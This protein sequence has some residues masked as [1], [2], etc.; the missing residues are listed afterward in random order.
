MSETFDGLNALMDTSQAPLPKPQDGKTTS[1]SKLSGEGFTVEMP[2]GSEYGVMPAGSNNGF[3][4]GQNGMP[5]PM[6]VST[7]PDPAN[8]APRDNT[9]RT[10]DIFSALPTL[11]LPDI[12]P[13][14]D[15]A[16]SEARLAGNA[17]QAGQILSADDAVDAS[18]GYVRGIGEN[19][20][21][22]QVND[23]LNQVGHARI[24]FGSNK[25]GDADV[26]VPLID[27]PNSLFFSQIGLRANEERTTTNLGLGYRQYEDGWMWGVNSFYDYDITGSNSRVGVGGELWA[28]YLKFAAN[29]YFRVTDWH[30]STLHEM[31]DYDER[32]ANGFDIRAEGYLPDY[33]QVGAFAKYEQYFGDGVSLASTTS[34]GELKSNPS[35]S[36][37]GLSYTPF[38]LI[39]FKGQTSRGDSNDSQVG[40]ELSYRFGVPLSQ[41]LDTDNVDLM[42]NLAGNRYDFVDR[43]YNIVMQ[44]RKQELLRIALPPALHGEA[45]QTHPVTV[46][47]LKAKYGLKSLRWSAPE[48]LA[49]GGEIRQ[50]GLTTADITLPEYVFMDRNGGPQGYRVTVVGE[51]N[52]GNPS[53][54]AEMWVNVIPSVETVTQLTVTPNQS[55]VANNRDQFTAVA[56]LQNDKGEVL[57]DKAVTFSVSGLKNPEGVTIY[58]ADGNSGQ[59]LTVISGPDGMATVKIISK[60]AGKGL[61]KAKMRNGNSRT[62]SIVYIA[63]LSTAKIK[64]LELTNNKAVADGQAKNI[65]VATVTDQFDNQVENFPL[66]ARADNGAT[67]TDPNQQT[68]DNGQVT[69]RFSSETA[70]D[71]KL[72]VEGTGTSKSVTSQFVADISTA[73]IQSA[74][75]TQDGAKADGKAKNEVLVTVTDS[76]NNPLAGAPVTIKVPGTARYQ[77]QPVSGLTDSRGQLRVSISNTKAGSDNYTFSINGDDAV[78]ALKFVA[79]ETTATITDASLVIV[80]NNQKADGAAANSVRATIVDAYNNPVPGIAV[81]FVT[82]HGALPSQ[83]QINTDADG[84]ALFELTNTR[85]G[86]TKVTAQVNTK[87]ASKTVMF[88]ADSSTAEILASNL[89]ITADNSAADGT[90]V[91]SVKAIVTDA[92]GNVVPYVAVLFT[93]DNGASPASQSLLTNEQGEVTF[94]LTSTRAVQVAVKAKINTSEPSVTVT[95]KADSANPDAQKSS[96][97]ADPMTIVADGQT[98]STL[99]FILKD[100]Q[101]N[102]IPGQTVVFGTALAGTTVSG[103]TE[104]PDGTYTA[105]L[106]GVKAGDAKVSITLNG[107]AFAVTPVTVKLTADNGNLSGDKSQ[108]TAVPDTIVA[109]GKTSSTLTLSLK[110]ANDNAV[111]GQEVVFSTTL[112][113]TVFSA[114]RDNADGTYTATLKGTKS[115]TAKIKVTVNNAVLA[116]AEVSVKLTADSGNL[117]K[118]KSSLA[119]V[120]DTIVAD[121]NTTSAITLTLR[122]VNNNPVAGQTALFS[123]TLKD[124]TFG[125]VTDNQDGTYTATLKGTKSGNAQ[126]SVTLNGKAFAVAPVTVKLTA[127]SS[128]LD[129]DKSSL[130]AAPLSIVANDTAT[131]SLTLTL[132]DGNDNPVPGQTVL[133]S[134]T[135]GGTT[136]SGVTD[137]RDGTYTATL[138]G[139]TAGDAAL[140]VT[141]NGAVLTVAP[142]TVKLT[143]DSGNLDKDQSVLEASPL[144]IV[145]NDTTTS[146]LKLTLKDANGNLVSGQTVLFST[147]L[148]GTTFSGVT[149]NQDGTYTAT[150]KGKTAGDAALKVTVNGTELPV[151]QVIVTLT[152]DSTNLDKN[153]SSLTAAPLSIVADDASVSDLKLT[154]KDANGNLVPGQQVLFSTTLGGTTFSGVTDNHDGT[155][156][157]TLKGTKAGD[158]LLTVT[159]NGAVLEVAPVTVKLTADS[160]NLDKDQSVLE[161]S[162]LS[163]VANDTTT[164]ALK[165][166]LKDGN[167]NLVSGQTVLFSTTLANTTFGTVTDNQDGTYTAT[168]KGKTAGDAVIKVTVGGNPLDVAPVTV[169]LTPDSTN[170][171]KNKSSL[172]AVPLSIVADDTSVSDLKLILK[173]ANGN[174]V[175]GQQV[176]FSTTLGG[177]TFSGVTDNHD[178]TYTATL[179]GTKAGDALLTVTVNGAVLE[180]APVTVTLTADNGNLDKNQSVLEAAPLN[181]V[182]NGTAESTL[183]L[184]LKDVNGNLVSGQVVQFTTTLADTT[185][186][187]V[188]DNRDGTY[189]ATLKGTKSGDAP[190][191]VIVNGTGL[192]VAPV[193]VTLTPDSANPDKDKSVLTA[194][195]LTIVADDTATS[196]LKLTLKDT[197]GNLIPGQTVLFS[198]DLADTTFSTVKDNHDGT[199]TAT[200]KGTKSGTAALKVT[201]NGAVLEV[202]PVSVK[203]IGDKDHLDEDKSSLTAAPLSIVANNTATSSLTLTLKDVNDNPV[204]G[205]TV[206]FSTDLADTT[207][208]AVKDNQDG[209]YTATLKGTK[210]GNALLKVT[211]NGAVLDVAPV[212]VKLTA[213]SGN[214]DKN[215]S[216]LTAAP[217]SIVANNTTTSE[218]KLT[219]KDANGNLVSGQT[220]LFST[221]LANTTFGTVTDNQDGTYTATLK[222]KTA[223]DAVIKVTVG[224]NALEV[225]P[226]TVTLTADSSNLDNDK[227]VLEAT[228]LSIVADDATESTLKLT[229]KDVNGNLVSGQTVLFSTTLGGTTISAVKDNQDGTYTALLKGKTA[230]AAEIK[231]T[232]GGNALEVAPVTVT[233]TPD[234]SNLDEGK[235]SLTA[236]PL[237]IVANNITESALTLT[238]KDVNGNLVPGQTVLF[239]TGLADT[240][241]SGVTDNQDGTYTATLKG[242]KAGNA[243]LKVTINGAVLEVAPVTVKLIGDQD[244]LDKGKSAL[245]ADPLTIVANNTTTSL[246]KLTLKDVNDN[247]VTGQ[248]VL[249]ST[250]L[251]NT[252]F[253]TVTDNQDGTYTANLQG[254]TAG[255]AVIKVTVGGTELEVAPVTVTL[256]ADS[257]NLDKEKSLLTAVPL[258]IVADDAT[259]SVLTLTLK[260]GNDNLVAGQT[261]LFSTGLADTTFSA[262]KDNQDGTYTATLKGTKA[263][264]A[265][266]KVTVNGAVLEVAPVTV[267]LTADSSNLDKNKSV[268]TADPLTIVANN[269]TMSALKLTLKDANGNLVSGQTVLFSTDLADT[270]F[271]TVVANPDGTYTTTLKGTKAGDALLKVTVNGTVLEV[272]PVTVKLTADSSNLDKNKSSLTAAPLTIVANNTATSEVTLTLKDAYDN[273]VAGQTVLFST[274][275]ANTTFGTVTDNH[276]G[277][278]T[279]TLKGT[280]AGD[281]EIKVTVGGN[282]LEV[283]SVTVKLTADSSNLD[284][285]K[286]VLTATPLTIVA[287][288]TATSA[289]KLTLKDANDNPVAGQTVLFSTTLGG[290]TFSGV[291]DN[292]DGTY[293]ATLKGKTA[294]DAPLTVT[295]NGT[296]M[297]VAVVTVTLTGD[298]ATATI[299]NVKLNGALT[300]KIA[301]GTD[302]FEFIAEVRD[303]NGNAVS[304]V[305]VNWTSTAGTSAKL[306]E[307]SQQTDAAGNATVKLTSTKTPVYDIVI[308]AAQGS[309]TVKADKEVSF[310]ELFSTSVL[311]IDAI[312]AGDKPVNG[313]HVKIFSVDGTELLFETT[314][315][316]TGKFKV[317]LV[318]GK[319]AVKITANNYDDYDDFMVVKSG[320]DTNFKF[321]LSPALG[322]EFGR[323]ILQ[324]SEAPNDLDAHLL[325]PPVGGGSRIHVYYPSGSKDPAGA[326]AS[327]DKDQ[328]SPPGVETITIRKGHKGT[329]TYFVKRYSAGADAKLSTAK[330]L[331]FLNKDLVLKSGTSRMMSFDA[332]DVV[333]PAKAQWIVFDIIVD[334][335][336]E[337]QVVPKGTVT[338]VEPT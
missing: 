46:S 215:K 167:G 301:N 296:E 28:N 194:A 86:N 219:L 209:T 18:L 117:D 181:I 212:T 35:V 130:T 2:S 60:S 213:D 70:G 55:L 96:L 21:N 330:V 278:Y 115:G 110:D 158:A 329:Y 76:R 40:M 314:T 94:S 75:V 267:K 74:V 128:N 132:K 134:T 244:N 154:L 180:V 289:L 207:F 277:T 162:P 188:T 133:F 121:G 263:G 226:V 324:W 68:D 89:T 193:T 7:L 83:M 231:V 245:T 14:D 125:T 142:V 56:L 127:D 271:D 266:L 88:T 206:L 200:L 179:K 78:R 168:L 312:A 254:K 204:I 79:D 92:Q 321:A 287:N 306:S 250:G 225:A 299:T 22:Q 45:A 241:F 270:T 124:T 220:V 185:F 67:V 157:A 8:P 73:K 149:D 261:V 230:G 294:G 210:A 259:E 116:V 293:T 144:S 126:I 275:L 47:V 71:S 260:D 122:D 203:L 25:T 273:P 308:S 175:P 155:Y 182:A 159:V 145:A 111:S 39:T 283:A 19:L 223:G 141:V 118:G 137:N 90:S 258:T 135:L 288:N 140:K 199:Y 236:V 292:Q 305:T 216:S 161:A 255:A 332:P 12:S 109:D 304:G 291:T 129:K 202:A 262:V 196:S 234:S 93:A 15:A 104:N 91:N 336:N 280:K 286:S 48:L 222:G 143:A 59:T 235:S 105:T 191:T 295:V 102:L 30:Q 333:V 150:L 139:K 106:K 37:L 195:P 151:A 315:D 327:L 6:S 99:H 44:Y 307:T 43:N 65:A 322:T 300:R 4:S 34:S 63:D 13:E 58:D 51:D 319:Y 311:V 272:A 249:F 52:E 218:V 164:S 53:N 285:D 313:A 297:P 281:A 201:V 147:T 72:V 224:G 54:T 81:Q 61:L 282:V 119:A 290:T 274:T 1:G 177:T 211:V 246:V 221:T 66:T 49:N 257:S 248:T 146:A 23:W 338:S 323:I 160:G 80:T 228:P 9:V 36:T 5:F 214:L 38:P 233:L 334:E 265:L 100:R 138:K 10:D 264:D 77:T 17:S 84:N 316:A 87:S 136:F 251:A 174:L 310:E 208:S 163:V 237:T 337:V 298:A 3:I 189:T 253:G 29:G 20:L 120:P 328:Q 184:T 82:D 227:S 247:P 240:T 69:I 31:R 165:L 11:G 113:D 303:A 85:A 186:S 302:S 190:L 183:K 229:L 131:S 98:T 97:T 205:Q 269:T 169:T 276:D 153:K 232:V 57:A 170:L 32:P 268:L 192:A 173:D 50:T 24:Q 317:D 252:T 256:T 103:T 238:L 172:T 107:K 242:T 326:D 284:K 101:G 178:G 320:A 318:G 114:V 331:L 309:Q 64:T 217:L 123:T 197:Y 152:P 325:V 171:D 62:E 42:R 156:T 279:A 243:L 41:Q 166:T 33:P 335:N 26:L 187:G 112:A 27:N 148:G 95:F 176:L 16:Q 198:T 239:S 108:L